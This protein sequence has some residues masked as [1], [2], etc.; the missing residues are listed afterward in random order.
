MRVLRDKKK[1]NLYFYI[2]TNDHEPPHVHVFKGSKRP[3]RGDMKVSI[4]SD[5]EPPELMILKDYSEITGKDVRSALTIV[6]EAQEELLA[7]WSEIHG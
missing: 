4:G 5:S 2:Y 7:I 3:R 6:G 1:N